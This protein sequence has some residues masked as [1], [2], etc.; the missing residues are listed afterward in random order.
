[1][2]MI[3]YNFLCLYLLYD[4]AS[5]LEYFNKNINCCSTLYILEFGMHLIVSIPGLS[6]LTYYASIPDLCVLTYYATRTTSENID[7]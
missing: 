4:S 2:S 3:C 7:I 5:E 1:M 6:N